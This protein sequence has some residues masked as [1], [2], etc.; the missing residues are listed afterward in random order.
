MNALLPETLAILERLVAFPTI[1]SEPNVR[2]IDDVA[3]RLEDCGA[4]VDVLMTEDGAKANLFATIGPHV[5]GGIVLSGHTDVVPADEADWRSD[6]FKLHIDAERAYG[7]GTCD[8]KGFVAAALAMAP[9]FAE[10]SLEKPIHYA[11]TYDEEVG[12]LGARQLVAW[13]SVREMQPSTAIIGEP[14][15]MRVVEGHKGCFEY[16]T[17]FTG[18][19]GHGSDPAAGASAVEAAVRYSAELLKVREALK[20]RVPSV[21]AFDPPFTTLQVGCIHGGTAR[22]VIAGECAVEWEMRPVDPA[23]AS[24]VL[25]TIDALADTLARE[26]REVYPQCAIRREVV[27]EVA[28]LVPDGDMTARDLALRLTGANAAHVVPFGT[29]A[30]LFQTAGLSA[31]VCGPGSITE[32]HKANEF[33]TLRQLSSALNFLSALRRELTT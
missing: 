33:V 27:G 31:V 9:A 2:L 30:G 24:F 32:A 26:M 23:D 10:A 16:T 8:M 3:G 25:S 4:T 20:A 22:N 7:R 1:S 17:H 5:P 15:E 11:L 13:L 29:E 12:C 6:P 14:T 18:S 19:E 28:G 21:S